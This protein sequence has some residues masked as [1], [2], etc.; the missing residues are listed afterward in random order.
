MTAAHYRELSKALVVVLMLIAAGVFSILAAGASAWLGIVVYWG[1]LTAKNI[2]DFVANEL[3]K[4]QKE[5]EE[6]GV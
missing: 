1:V 4:E 5:D 6:D 3:D 2:C